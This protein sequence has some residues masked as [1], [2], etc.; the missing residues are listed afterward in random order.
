MAVSPLVKAAGKTHVQLWNRSVLQPSGPARGHD[1]WAVKNQYGTRPY[2]SDYIDHCLGPVQPRAAAPSG[3]SFPP[4]LG[5]CG[6][7]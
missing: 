6:G 2:I 7:R 3:R 1:S 4:A 5:A